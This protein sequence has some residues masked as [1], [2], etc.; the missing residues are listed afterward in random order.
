MDVG[1]WIASGKPPP[2][3]LVGRLVEA[4]LVAD[5]A[6][7]S[8]ASRSTVEAVEPSNVVAIGRARP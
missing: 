5:V 8:L 6:A 1:G 4:V 3:A 7:R 2:V